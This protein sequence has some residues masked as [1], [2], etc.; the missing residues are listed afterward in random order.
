MRE[1]I[2]VYVSNSVGNYTIQSI[3]L[4]YE[5]EKIIVNHIGLDSRGVKFANFQVLRETGEICPSV[6]IE[7]GFLSNVDE[8]SYISDAQNLKIVALVLLKE[9][10]KIS[11]Y[12]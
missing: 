3:L 5:I 10:I 9:I 7:F 1:G 2:E 11:N 6:L 12:E 4:G 8:S